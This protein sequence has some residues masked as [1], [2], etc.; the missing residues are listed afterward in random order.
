[1]KFYLKPKIITNS[2]LPST[3]G[4]KVGGATEYEALRAEKLFR[5]EYANQLN[6]NLLTFAFTV[7][8]AG[9]I[10]F[11]LLFEFSGI[12]NPSANKDEITNY[13][14]IIDSTAGENQQD[15]QVEIKNNTQQKDWNQDQTYIVFV[16]Y[17]FAC[18]FL[19]PCFFSRINFRYTVKNSLR[20][21]QLTDYIRE[22]IQFDD[23]ESW[24][25]F[26]REFHTNYFYQK[27]SGV[28]GAKD[29]PY[30]IN[31]ISILLSASVGIVG[32][33]SMKTINNEY[34]IP[35]WGWL[36]FIALIMGAIIVKMI[37]PFFS[38]N[39]IT[40]KIPCVVLVEFLLLIVLSMV[41]YKW[42]DI[43]EYFII[44]LIIISFWTLVLQVCILITPQYDK[45]IELANCVLDYTRA[46]LQEGNNKPQNESYKKRNLRIFI[47]FLYNSV[48]VNSYL[49]K[50]KGKKSFN[51]HVIL[52]KCK[53]ILYQL[54]INNKDLTREEKNKCINNHF[55]TLSRK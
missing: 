22:K 29:I 9:L 18:F 42:F 47:E 45:E 44:Q 49:E 15:Y 41:L 23:G 46:K 10:V 31:I 5:Y 13:N 16:E 33:Y 27:E 35:W 48:V 37:E 40:S 54:D 39:K 32:I 17:F 4:E 43:S 25:K 11:T 21:G 34:I 20:I 52:K 7:F 53:T 30:W 36:A 3:D 14:I 24:E 19:L 28:G 12:I 50:I 51:R 26:K 38:M 55:D 8:T 6:T 2:S 1:M